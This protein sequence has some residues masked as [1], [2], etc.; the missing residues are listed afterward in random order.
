[1]ALGQYGGPE[2]IA[3]M[4][5][6]LAGAGGRLVTGAAIAVDGGFAA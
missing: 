3:A 4:V 6:H 2:D 5:A 1:M